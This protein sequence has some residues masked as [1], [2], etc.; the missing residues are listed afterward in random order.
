MTTLHA[1]PYNLSATGFY[2][3]S[4]EDYT[5]KSECHFDCYG[6]LIEEFEIQFIAG[7]DA[8]LFNAC[9][10]NQ[11]SLAI[12]FEQIEPL[13][14]YEKV[15]LY[16]LLNAGYTL[17]QALDKVD[18]PSIAESNLIDTA[19]DLFDEIYAHE[20]PENLRIYIDYKSFARDCE[21]G[22]DLVEFEHNGTTYTCTNANGI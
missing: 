6:D 20:I 22:G 1:T 8:Q 10:I 3:E 13:N 16:F 17:T 18:E 21:S 12:W 15:G 9:D 7:D 14:D 2:F 11:A 5:L 4:I 19:T